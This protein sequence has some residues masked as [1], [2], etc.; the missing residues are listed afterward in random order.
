MI[1]ILINLHL[2]FYEYIV[3]QLH[4]IKYIQL[5]YFAYIVSEIKKIEKRKKENWQNAE[6]E[7]HWASLALRNHAAPTRFTVLW[8]DR[9]LSIYF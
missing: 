7:N 3:C 6:F 5:G 1:K 8:S 4:F 9:N 2:L